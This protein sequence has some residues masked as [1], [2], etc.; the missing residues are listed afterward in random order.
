MISSR[1]GKT[2]VARGEEYLTC[3]EIITFLLE[4]LAKELSADEEREFERH[5]ALCPSC[6]AYLATY[7]QTIR[8]GRIA[9]RQEL[10]AAPPELAPALVRSILA[11]RSAE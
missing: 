8:L 1:I 7:R 6:I 10:A 4:Y 3:E 2:V 5:L 11:A 9:M